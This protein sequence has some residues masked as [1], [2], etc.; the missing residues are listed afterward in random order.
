MRADLAAS[1]DQGGLSMEREMMEE[2]ATQAAGMIA[3]ATALV[4]LGQYL[5]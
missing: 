3:A 5:R 4:T 1:N 2:P